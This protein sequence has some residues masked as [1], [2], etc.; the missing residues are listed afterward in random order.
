[1]EKGERCAGVSRSHGGRWCGGV[2]SLSCEGRW[3]CKRQGGSVRGS[4]HVKGKGDG[5]FARDRQKT[6]LVDFFASS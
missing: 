6:N 1:M 4:G 5:E 2:S 3:M